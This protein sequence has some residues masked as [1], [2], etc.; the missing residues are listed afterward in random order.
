VTTKDIRVPITKVALKTNYVPVRERADVDIVRELPVLLERLV[1]V[2][3]ETPSLVTNRVDVPVERVRHEPRVKEVTVERRTDRSTTLPRVQE[4]YEDVEVASRVRAVEESLPVEVA[5]AV[6]QDRTVD[7]PV[8]SIVE[9]L[10]TYPRDVEVALRTVR[11]A[12]REEEVRY[13][14][15]A[16]Y[17]DRERVVPVERV[18]YEDR[19]V[20]VEVATTQ[21]VLQAEEMSKE[22]SLVATRYVDRPVEVPVERVNVVE[23]G[24]VKVPLLRIKYEDRDIPFPCDTLKRVEREVR[25]PVERAVAT[26]RDVVREVPKETLVV[27][28]RVVE[29]PRVSVV[30][31]EV[32]RT[33]EVPVQVPEG[34]VQDRVKEVEKDERVR[35]VVVEETVEVEVEVPVAE[36]V[37]VGRPV[38]VERQ[39]L[40]EREV[41][42]VVKVPLK[43]PEE[44]RVD[45][46]V[47]VERAVERLAVARVPRDRRVVAQVPYSLPQAARERELRTIQATVNVPD[48]TEVAKEVVG[49]VGVRQ[50]REKPKELALRSVVEREMVKES[51]VTLDC[52]RSV[53]LVKETPGRELLLPV[54]VPVEVD[55]G[56]GG[57]GGDGDGGADPERV[58]AALD[59]EVRQG[60]ARAARFA[61]E[62]QELEAALEGARQRRLALRRALAQAPPAPVST[63]RE[64]VVEVEV[65]REV[66][67]FGPA[68]VAGGGAVAG[69]AEAEAVA[70]VKAA[71]AALEAESGRTAVVAMGRDEAQAQALMARRRLERVLERERAL[72]SLEKEAALRAAVAKTEPAYVVGARTHARTHKR[73]HARIHA[74]PTEPAYSVKLSAVIRRQGLC[75]CS[76]GLCH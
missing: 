68:A 14:A 22:V 63:V 64:E 9:N 45:R 27:R 20:P 65:T 40:C 31:Q 11:R 12:E 61:W 41:K 7:V 52:P 72:R 3:V 74:R 21:E 70:A 16:E 51:S 18:R 75:H 17:T 50:T 13:D 38:A 37:R 53:C 69:G 42:Q 76:M 54:E 36:A 62:L 29:V 71:R 66:P 2:S 43:V 28:E 33:V 10:V 6:Y 5:R 4:V 32:V 58:A 59:A 44:R 39:T 19:D 46:A 23:T 49:E 8:H 73:T 25:C 55:M 60:R 56:G 47:T 1:H 24:L 48:V 15:R 57:G 26:D 35:A 34:R 67:D 30:E